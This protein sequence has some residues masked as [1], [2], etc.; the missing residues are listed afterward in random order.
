MFDKMGDFADMMR[1]VGAMKANMEKM[2][3]N[4]ARVEV[5]G[6]AGGGVVTARVNGKF[7]LMSLRID[8]KLLADGDTELLEDLVR[9][10]VNQALTK[11]RETAAQAVTGQF[12]LPPGFLTGT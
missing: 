5:E 6:A 10:A 4:L 8:P 12:P 7:E 11:A 3:E 9:A 1:Q 2:A